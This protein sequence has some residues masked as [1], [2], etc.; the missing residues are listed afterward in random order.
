MDSRKENT[1]SKTSLVDYEIVQFTPGDRE[2][3]KNWSTAK[4]LFTVTCATVLTFA[5]FVTIPVVA[6][7]DVH[8]RSSSRQCVR[9]PSGP[10]R[11]LE[12]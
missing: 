2:D 11:S 9:L 7:Q 1:E 3:P 5:A 6:L 10:L 4:K 8:W 12:A